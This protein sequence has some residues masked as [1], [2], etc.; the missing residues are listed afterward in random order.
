MFF[1]INVLF[2]FSVKFFYMSKSQI[3]EKKTEL[4]S[5]VKNLYNQLPDMEIKSKKN[6]QE[7][8]FFLFAL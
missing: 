2:C 5:R 7:F 8:N 4:T 1:Q 3:K 6:E